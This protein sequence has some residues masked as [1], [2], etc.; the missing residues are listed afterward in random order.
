MSV[1]RCGFVRFSYHKITLCTT[2]CGV[3]W[4]I[5]IC[6]VVQLLHFAGDF[7]RFRCGQAV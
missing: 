2:Q 4:F 1:V 6:S 3:V 5:T 7:G